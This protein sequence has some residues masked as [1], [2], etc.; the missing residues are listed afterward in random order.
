MSV[1][2]LTEQE[3]AP[4]RTRTCRVCSVEINAASARCPYCRARQFKHQPVLGWRGLLVAVVAVAGAV[5]ITR[6]VIDA[7]N[8][9]LH[10][11][12]VES[13]N[14]ATFV[15]SGWQ[16]QLLAGPH[17]TAIAAYVNP[18]SAAD[19]ETVTAT[20]GARGTPHSRLIALYEKLGRA[21]GVARGYH[22][23]VT[24][25][26]DQ[27]EWTV[28]YTFDSAYYA[29]FLFDS[30]KGSIGMN[31]TLS[32]ASATALQSLTTVL[33]GSAEPKCDG[34]AFSSSDRADASVPLAP[35]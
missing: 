26:G 7:E 23:M 27:V 12:A 16:N 4:P 22:G 31:V 20:L 1:E 10:F 14:L 15:P 17:G 5:L 33:P 29:V 21:P 9:G 35:R 2:E 11:D 6:A 18:S 19:T 34:P 32:A 30:C 28:Y 24:F 3:E 25:P 13:V 8:S